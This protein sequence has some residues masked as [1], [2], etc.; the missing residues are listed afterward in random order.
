[1][2]YC[3]KPG[4]KDCSYP[5]AVAGNLSGSETAYCVHPIEGPQP[6]LSG[7]LPLKQRQMWEPLNIGDPSS[8]GRLMIV[9]LDCLLVEDVT[10]SYFPEFKR[11]C[12]Q[13]MRSQGGILGWTAGADDVLKALARGKQGT[14]LAESGHA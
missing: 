1:M 2:F 11:A 10:E 8:T 12:L 13:M 7:R 3:V 4:H 14:S 9:V 5:E 6:D